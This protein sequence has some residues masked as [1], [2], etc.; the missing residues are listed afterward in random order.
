MQVSFSKL[1]ITVL[2]TLLLNVGGLLSAEEW[3]L[4]AQF[5]L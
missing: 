3:L 2:F 5:W 1:K 4:L